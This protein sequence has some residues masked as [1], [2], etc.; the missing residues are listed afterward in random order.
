M[1]DATETKLVTNPFG[2]PQTE[3]EMSIIKSHVD[4]LFKDAAPWRGELCE[5]PVTGGY[6]LPGDD[7]ISRQK[8]LACRALFAGEWF[9]IYGPHDASPLPLTDAELD[10][11]K[12]TDAFSH[13][14]SCFA[15][16]LR[17]HKW[18][19][20]SHPSFADFACG[21]TA[22]GH[23]PDLIKKAEALRKRYP[24]RPLRGLGPGLC[25]QPPEQHAQIMARYRR[26]MARCK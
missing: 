21:C 7:S 26:S 19:F 17:A 1:T 20:N 5:N 24:P 3:V 23:A 10:E 13:I 18:D 25:W 14:V 16:S 22:S 12:Y 15:Y 6:W 8:R 4:R 2:A 9:A 11:L